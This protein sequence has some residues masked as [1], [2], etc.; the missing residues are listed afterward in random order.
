MFYSYVAQKKYTVIQ[1]MIL[2]VVIFLVGCSSSSSTLKASQESPHLPSKQGEQ[3][4]SEAFPNQGGEYEV[5]PYL[6]I[7]GSQVGEITAKTTEAELVSSYGEEQVVEAEYYVAEGFCLPG[8]RL[9]PEDEEKTIEIFWGDQ[10]NRQFPV[11]LQM[12]GEA[13]K[14]QTEDGISLGTTVHQLGELNGS[15]FDFSGFGWD[16]GGYVVSWK[17]GALEKYRD[18]LLLRLAE[19]QVEP[20]SHSLEIY[21]DATFSSEILKPIDTQVTVTRLTVTFPKNALQYSDVEMDLQ[22]E[23]SAG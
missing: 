17:E 9:F 14:W 2:M 12:F 3:Q 22:K 18:T 11:R 21:G 19:K 7:P 10:E 1:S 13:S 15:A 5:S 16:Y 8:T 20:S 6:I 23:C 4:G